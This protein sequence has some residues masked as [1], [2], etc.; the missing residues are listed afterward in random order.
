MRK[1]YLFLAGALLLS[2]PAFSQV[3]FERHADDPRVIFEQDFEATP[4]LTD[5][6]AY[7]EWSTTPID[8]ILEL[9][10]YAK[11]GSST[12]RSVDIYSDENA[13]DWSIFAVRTD[14]VSSEHPETSSGVGIVIFNGVETSSSAS[15]KANK[16]YEKD[17]YTI[18]NDRGEDTERNLAFEQYGESGGQSYFKYET[19][20]IDATKISSSHYSTTTHSTK[21]YRRDLYV[22]GLDI[23]DES[24]YRLTFYIKT[25]NLIHGIP[26]SM[27]I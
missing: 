5:K 25:K 27:Q 17:S 3:T 22:R 14:S 10:Y 20:G 8:T 21:N 11:L 1:F 16:V 4:G 24:S 2:M 23:E 7:I 13:A 26:C 15:E 9:E 12:P 6:E 19:G 18:V